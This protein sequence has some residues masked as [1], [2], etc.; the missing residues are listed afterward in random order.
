MVKFI[1]LLRPLKVT[2]LLVRERIRP[3]VDLFNACFLRILP[4]ATIPQ[5]ERLRLRLRQRRTERYTLVRESGIRENPGE[6]VDRTIRQGFELTLLA[7]AAVLAVEKSDF[8]LDGSYYRFPA[9]RT[10]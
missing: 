6:R 10:V 1:R 2:L 4:V 8:T 5:G 3:W 7:T 9:Y